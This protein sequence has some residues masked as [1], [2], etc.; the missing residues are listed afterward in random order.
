MQ[1]NTIKRRVGIQKTEN[2]NIPSQATKFADKMTVLQ[3]GRKKLHIILRLQ[4]GPYFNGV[5]KCGQGEQ[6]LYII[7][8]TLHNIQPFKFLSWL[9]WLK[10]SPDPGATFLNWFI[11]ITLY[12]H[13]HS[14]VSDSWLKTLK[15]WMIWDTPDDQHITRGGDSHWCNTCCSK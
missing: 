6:I 9:P 1:S 8:V 11:I 14:A 4:S 15:L 3:S 2:L 10:M 5:L 7:A 13:T 12:T